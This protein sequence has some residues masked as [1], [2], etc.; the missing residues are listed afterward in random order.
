MNYTY[1]QLRTLVDLV[2]DLSMRYGVTRSK[3][4]GHCDV[5]PRKACP[6][7]DVQAFFSSET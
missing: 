3:I 5:D 4:L 2:R 1:K 7:F 6:C